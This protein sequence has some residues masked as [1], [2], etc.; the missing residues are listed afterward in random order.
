MISMLRRSS[1]DWAR[2][3]TPAAATLPNM[4]SV[5]PPSTGLGICW[6][7]APMCGNSPSTNSTAP[8]YSPT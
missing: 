4:T 1:G 2:M 7:M 5:A 3:R 8:M 6:T